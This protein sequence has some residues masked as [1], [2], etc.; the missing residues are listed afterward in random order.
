MSG[1][2][3][4]PASGGA[5]FARKSVKAIR[6]AYHG[7]ANRPFYHIVVMEKKAP[8]NGHVIEQLGSYDPM[9][10]VHG[11]KLCAINVE[12]VTHWIGEGTTVSTPC[13]ILFGLA[14]L[15]PIH[16]RSY[17]TAWRN[18]RQQRENPQKESKINSNADAS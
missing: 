16:P 9:A 10:N 13:A 12:R 3:L 14:G 1:S 15:L 8:R 11:E 18:R 5:K 4:F 6:F 17:M 7:C 2:L